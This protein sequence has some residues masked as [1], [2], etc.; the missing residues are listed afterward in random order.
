[1]Q[2]E[3]GGDIFKLSR[4]RRAIVFSIV[5]ESELWSAPTWRSMLEVGELNK[6]VKEILKRN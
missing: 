6:L 2:I 3:G 1:M 5:E 4:A